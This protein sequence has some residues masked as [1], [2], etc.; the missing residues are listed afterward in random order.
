MLPRSRPASTVYRSTRGGVAAAAGKLG[1]LRQ[2]VVQ[3]EREPD[4]F[5]L[6]VLADQVHAVVPVAAAHQRQ[7]V[8]AE[9]QAVVDRADAMLVERADVVGNLRQVVVRLLVR[10]QQPARQKRHALVEH[11]GVAGGARRS[12]R[13]RRAARGS[14]RRNAC[15]RRGP[16]GGCHQCCTSP[17]RNW[18]RGGAQQMLAQQAGLGMHQRHRV[19]QLV[20]EAERAA[21][22]VEARPRPHAAGERLIDQPAVGQEIDGRVGRFDMH[23]ARASGSSS[24]RRLPAPGRRSAAPRKR[25]TSCRAWFVTDRRRR[26]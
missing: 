10:P 12:G 22:L 20:A 24:A 15:A 4:A 5:A 9:T 21:G 14:R 1:E 2:H 3:E 16:T 25:C 6:A 19:L 18:W 8:G 26:G 7:A 17:S 11:A 13:S 23:R